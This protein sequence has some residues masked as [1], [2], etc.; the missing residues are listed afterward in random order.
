MSERQIHGLKFEKKII[1]EFG[2]IPFSSYTSE[3]DAY[4]ESGNAYQIKLI[5]KGRN[6]ELGDFFRNF[7][8]AQDFYLIVGFWEGNV[9]NIVSFHK[10]FFSKEGWR[11][12]LLF[13]FHQELYSWIKNV[14][15]DKSYDAQWKKEYIF[16]RKLFGKR[17]IRLRFKR[18]HK[19]Q[20]RVQCAIPNKVF[21]SHFVS[22]CSA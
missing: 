19:K 3:F 4:D 2:L 14:S 22:K 20:K 1:K 16:W 15:N 8:K 9:E 5:K 11:N 18:D 17:L 10:I 6:I 13:D 21:F 7:N 12:L